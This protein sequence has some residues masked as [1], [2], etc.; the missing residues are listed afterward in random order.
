MLRREQRAQEAG[1]QSDHQRWAE[2]LRGQHQR[3]ERPPL[4]PR[5]PP[6]RR[7]GSARRPRSGRPPSASGGIRAIAPSRRQTN[8]SAAAAAAA[9]AAWLLGKDQ[10][11]GRARLQ[12]RRPA[13]LAGP[14]LA[15]QRLDDRVDA[16]CQRPRRTAR[17]APSPRGGVVVAGRATSPR[18]SGPRT[19]EPVSRRRT[20][21]AR[22]ATRGVRCTRVG[23]ASPS[24]GC[25]RR[26]A[27]LRA[28]VG[29]VTAGGPCGCA[30][31][32]GRAGSPR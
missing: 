27:P 21:D 8:Q 23:E 22:P 15:H 29:S 12:R 2:A 3:G 19:G 4:P 10:S 18:P 13:G 6:A 28:A 31:V 17:R 24:T 14:V 20:P 7:G 9:I 26:E 25:R 32:Q 5:S 16:V 30:A 11:P 1:L